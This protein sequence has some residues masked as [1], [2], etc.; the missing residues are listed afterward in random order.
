MEV[1]LLL[2]FG[3][4]FVIWELARRGCAKDGC[5]DAE[6][7]GRCLGVEG[8]VHCGERCV[9]RKEESWMVDW[10]GQVL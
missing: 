2:E 1:W 10:R 5:K 7:I 9:E 4:M 6:V 3:G 8:Y